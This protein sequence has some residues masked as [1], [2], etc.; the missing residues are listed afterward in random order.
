MS[1]Q[2]FSSSTRSMSGTDEVGSNLS[3][4][5]AKERLPPAQPAYILRGH[6][7][8]VHAL[9]FTPDN[10]RLLTADADGWVVSWNV[11]LKRPVA[12]WKAHGTAVL[13]LGSWGLDR[14]IT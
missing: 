10:T 5:Q 8:Q 11:A 1:E 3:L 13:G 12:V 7:A 9:H 4:P 14:V 2:Q 6:A